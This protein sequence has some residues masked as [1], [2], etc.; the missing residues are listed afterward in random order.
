MAS[1]DGESSIEYSAI[2][3][4]ISSNGSLTYT[5]VPG[6]GFSLTEEINLIGLKKLNLKQISF[7]KALKWGENILSI[8][9]LY[10]ENILVISGNGP[11]G[12]IQRYVGELAYSNDAEIYEI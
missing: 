2:I 11:S 4:M 7:T 3:E 12:N 6:V 5:G 10:P 1:T 8:P 9:I